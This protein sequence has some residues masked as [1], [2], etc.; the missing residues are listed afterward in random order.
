MKNTIIVYALLFVLIFQLTSCKKDNSKT[1]NETVKDKTESKA[2]FDTIF[3]RKNPYYAFIKKN[4]PKALNENDKV[5]FFKES[6][7]DLDGQDEVILAFERDSDAGPFIQNLFV[8]KNENGII[9]EIKFNSN[10]EKYEFDNIELISLKGKDKPYIKLETFEGPSAIGF[11]IYEMVDNQIKQTFLSASVGKNSYEYDD[12]LTDSQKNGF[13]DGYTQTLMY[14]LFNVENIFSFEN[15]TFKLKKRSCVFENY[16][17]EVESVVT[18][19]ICLKSLGFT[20]KASSKRLDE[21]CLDKNVNELALN[22]EIW[23][24][25]YLKIITDGDDGLKIDEIEAEFGAILTV[26]FND[27]KKNVNYQLRFK[28]IETNEKWQITKIELIK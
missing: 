26:D 9:K 12:S 15:N 23:K 11:A 22:T 18:Q 7:L 14:E 28:L 13:F 10:Y 2:V 24:S 20:D 19:Y 4:H 3:D 21:L 25:A 27:S 5:S 6:D 1:Q 17:K 8:L 16:P